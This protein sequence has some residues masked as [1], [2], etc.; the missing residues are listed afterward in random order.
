MITRGKSKFWAIIKGEYNL[1][2]AIT[3]PP[4]KIVVSLPKK[5]KLSVPTP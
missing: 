5:V 3:P 1:R 2:V 4:K